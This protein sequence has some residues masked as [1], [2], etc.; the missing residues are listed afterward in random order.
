MQTVADDINSAKKFEE[1]CVEIYN[2]FSTTTRQGGEARH[3]GGIIIT[4]NSAFAETQRLIS[5]TLQ[6]SLF[7]LIFYECSILI[8]TV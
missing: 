7:K 5:F 3:K 6:K 2:D 4:A 1:L 8:N